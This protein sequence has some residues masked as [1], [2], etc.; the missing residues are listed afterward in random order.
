ME[1]RVQCFTAGC[2][3]CK[4]STYVGRNLLN[5][6]M[7]RCSAFGGRKHKEVDARDCNAFRCN[8]NKGLPRCDYCRGK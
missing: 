6:E 5:D 8:A 1:R 3:Q 2:E 4:E 7:Y